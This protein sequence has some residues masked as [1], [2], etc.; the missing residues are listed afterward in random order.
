MPGFCRYVDV[1]FVTIANPEQSPLFLTAGQIYVPFGAYETNLVSDPLTLEIGETR[2]T[3]L[4]GGFVRG[5]FNG[6]V[7]VFNGTNKKDGKNQIGSWGAN[8][9]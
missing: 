9:G 6:S 5:G 1:A 7:Y 8:L 3:A 4:Q 2:E